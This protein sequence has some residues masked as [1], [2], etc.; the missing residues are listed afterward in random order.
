VKKAKSELNDWGRPEDKRSDF[1][2]LVRG[3]YATLSKANRE[4]VE[5]EY[6]RMKPKDFDAAMS[7]RKRR[8]APIVSRFKR[9]PKT[10][11]RL[12]D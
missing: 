7:R 5:S 8:T 10:E 11:K 6:H 1:G 2:K 9:K 3:K 4:K 12:A